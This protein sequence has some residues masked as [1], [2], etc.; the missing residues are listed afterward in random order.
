MRRF[1]LLLFLLV[2]AIALSSFHAPLRN[3]GSSKLTTIV[4]DAG[5]GGKD[6]GAPGKKTNEKNVTLSIS[7]KLEKEL[8]VLLPNT[9][10]ILTRNDDTFVELHKRANRAS[11]NEADFFVSIHC[12]SNKS[13]VPHGSE[14][15]VLAPR[16]DDANLETIINENSAILLEDD[17]EENYEGFDPTSIPSYILFSL[18]KN[19]FVKQSIDLASKVQHNFEKKGRVN[20]GV[21]QAGYLVLWKA[22]T[23]AIL[24]ETGFISNLE[25]EKYLDS[26]LG[27]EHLTKAIAQ[28]IKAYAE[29]LD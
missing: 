15:Y 1:I 26:D 16:L 7:L 28:A 19:A 23:P 5:H 25:E 4:I 10:V 22:A 14:T 17:H 27:Q 8:K 18:V 24:I 13:S 12:N 20:R 6:P 3:P 9:K 21:K 11:S 29:E 2:S